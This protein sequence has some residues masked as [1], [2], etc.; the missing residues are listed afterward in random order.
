MPLYEHV[1]VTRRDISSQQVDNLT[2]TLTGI[3]KDGGGAVTK[4]EYWGLRNLAYRIK[5]NRKGHYVL[6][7]IDSPFPAVAEM[8]RV[9]RL[10]EDVIRTM[11]IRVDELEEEPSVVMQQKTSRD[12][13]G[14]R[15][16]RDGGRRPPLR[17]DGETGSERP[18]EEAK[19]AA[20]NETK[21]ESAP[22]E[23]EAKG[24]SPPAAAEAA[25][26]DEEKKGR[27]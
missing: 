7:N 17:G 12:D 10:N 18:A 20:E 21:S 27:L 23:D 14:R 8:E 6:L 9:L 5:K 13:R 26:N 3:I 2:E 25:T 24:E 11:T 1:F 19:A 4:T 15:D 22:A 16:G